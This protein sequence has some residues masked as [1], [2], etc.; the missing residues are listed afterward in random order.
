MSKIISLAFEYEHDYE[1]LAITSTLEDYRLAYFLNQQL[2]LKLTREKNSLVLQDNKG[3]FSIFSYTCHFTDV[4]WHLIENKTRFTTAT[5][6][7]TNLFPEHAEQSYLISEKKDV[8][9]FL[10]IEDLDQPLKP[11]VDKIKSITGVITA[12]ALN[13]KTLKSKDYLIF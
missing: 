11:L 6:L 3:T 4:C 7:E 12:Y 1:L 5:T 2:K 10:K 8:D 13:P 9:F